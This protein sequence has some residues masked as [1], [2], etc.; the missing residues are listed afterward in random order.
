M[1]NRAHGVDRCRPIAREQLERDERRPANGRALVLESAA[2]ELELLAKAEL[3]DRTVCHGTLT[4]VRASRDALD[5]VCPLGA[6]IG[7]LALGSLFGEL[8]RLRSCLLERQTELSE[9]WV[10]PT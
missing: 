5:L 9:R 6:Q 7:E 8:L 3:A 4:V 10:G 1:E 2:E